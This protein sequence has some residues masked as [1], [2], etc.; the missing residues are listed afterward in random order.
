MVLSRPTPSRYIDAGGPPAWLMK[1]V[2]PVTAPQNS[3]LA[4]PGIAVR[5]L[6]PAARAGDLEQHEAERGQPDEQ[7]HPVRADQPKIHQPSS[8]PGTPPAISSSEWRQSHLR[9]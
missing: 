3:P 9:Q 6:Q 4:A 8:V 5:R 7:P 1:L 2:K